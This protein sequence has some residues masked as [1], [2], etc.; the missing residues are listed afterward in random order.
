MVVI[1][2]KA[3]VAKAIRVIIDL[4]FVVL[5]ISLVLS[6][7][8]RPGLIIIDNWSLIDFSLFCVDTLTR[9]FDR[10][11]HSTFPRRILMIIPF[12]HVNSGFAYFRNIYYKYC[13]LFFLFLFSTFFRFLKKIIKPAT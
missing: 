8:L 7:S 6:A 2:S 12:H 10:I 3:L 1:D 5:I 4:S 13:T 11:G 9:P